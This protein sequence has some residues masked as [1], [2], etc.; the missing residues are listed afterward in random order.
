MPFSIVYEN[1]C[2]IIIIVK[3]LIPSA[4]L[5]IVLY[6]PV[7]VGALINDSL[8]GKVFIHFN[9]EAHSVL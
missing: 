1:S 7:T 6:N 9:R 4:V 5:Y 3:I 8:K 2:I